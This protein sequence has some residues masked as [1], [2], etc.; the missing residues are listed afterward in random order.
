MKITYKISRIPRKQGPLNQ[1][2]QS[3]YKLTETKVPCTWP[4]WVYTGP[5]V[6]IMVSS[7]VFFYRIPKCPNEWVS[8]SVH[9]LVLFFFCLLD[10]SNYDVLIL[11]Y[12]II[13]YYYPLV[14]C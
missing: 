1:H 10:L 3:S 2:N 9:A 7:S 12:L 14:A 6:Y 11:F 13:F 8:V 5:C 4:E